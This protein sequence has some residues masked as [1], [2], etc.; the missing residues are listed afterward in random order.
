MSLVISDN[1]LT[2]DGAEIT[3]TPQPVDTQVHAWS[4][5]S[6][7]RAGGYFV[8]VQAPGAPLERPACDSREALYLGAVEFPADAD[9][10]LN[11]WRAT[12]SISKL[13]ARL[14][15][16]N[17]TAYAGEYANEWERSQAIAATDPDAL[18]YFDEAEVWRRLNPYIITLA[19][20]AMGMTDDVLDAR[21]G[22]GAEIDAAL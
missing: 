12:Q 13:A 9:A 2:I 6:H 10:A 14:T 7:Y 17:N 16:Q 20:G 8:S 15:L 22:E 21:F 1:T 4:V 19:L 5:P 18:A 3:L 11:A